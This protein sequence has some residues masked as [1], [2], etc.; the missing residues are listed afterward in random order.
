MDKSQKKEVEIPAGVLE[1]HA[2][3]NEKEIQLIKLIHQFPRE[4]VESAE[5]MDPSIIANFVYELAREFNQFYHDYSVLRAES[6][7][8]VEFR[9]LL[10]IQVSK[11][12]REA[13]WLLGI[14][15]PERM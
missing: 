9:L 3:P 14:D 7:T 2:A 12:I 6:P 13:M 8:T 10:S 11:V 4:I 5:Q 1:E 15:L